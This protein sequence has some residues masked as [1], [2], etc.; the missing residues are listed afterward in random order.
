[1]S[2]FEV[3][4][5]SSGRRPKSESDPERTSDV[6]QI[7]LLRPA[8]KS[9]RCWWARARADHPISRHAA[10]L[11]KECLKQSLSA[12]LRDAIKNLALLASHAVG[13]L[14]SEPPEN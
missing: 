7:Y 2:V 4:Q 10:L 9:S 13:L 14:K 11:G 1:M 8:P 5:T 3:K 12:Y 6:P